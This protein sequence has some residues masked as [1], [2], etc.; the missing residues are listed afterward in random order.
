[1]NEEPEVSIGY[2]EFTDSETNERSVRIEVTN[3]GTVPINE[4]KVEW[5]Y[6]YETPQ[7]A[8]LDFNAEHGAAIKKATGQSVKYAAETGRRYGFNPEAG[9]KKGPITTGESRV[10]LYPPE[11]LADMLSIVSSLS[12]E[13]YHIAITMNG[14]EEMAVPGKVIGAFVTRVLGS[15]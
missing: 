14:K 13:R 10:Y 1:M 4:I 15:A 7:E 6:T 11:W 5:V 8:T 3:R 12:P 2:G 9:A